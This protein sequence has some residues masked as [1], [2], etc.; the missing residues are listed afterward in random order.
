MT[1]KRIEWVDHNLNLWWGC[2][3]VNE[4]C[5]NCT[6]IDTAKRLLREDIYQKDLPRR[7]VKTFYSDLKQLDK[8]AGMN[9]Q[10]P[11]VLIG[12]MM[13]IFESSHLVIDK[14]K[15]PVYADMMQTERK[16]TEKMRTEFFQAIESGRFKNVILLLLTKRPENVMKQIPKAWKKEFPSNVWVGTS[17]STQKETEKAVKAMSKIPANKF[18]CI[19]PQ[20]EEI[21]ILNISSIESIKYV[22]NAPEVGHN[23]R[24]FAIEWAKR[25]QTACNALHIPY[26]YKSIDRRVNSFFRLKQERITI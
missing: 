4:G 12:S 18:L 2:S 21:D 16:T 10:R 7:E 1:S 26:F 8:V 15:K 20:I 17:V 13:D 23:K 5:K 11:I 6:A 9:G 14:D 22:L 24:D 25:I 19:E 3:Q